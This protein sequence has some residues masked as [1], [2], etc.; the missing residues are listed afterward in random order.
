MFESLEREAALNQVGIGLCL[1]AETL[2]WFFNISFLHKEG[3]GNYTQIFTRRELRVPVI[4]SIVVM[5]TQQFTGC[6]AVFAYSTDMFINAGID[7]W[8]FL[9]LFIFIK[10]YR[11][12]Q[13]FNKYHTKNNNFQENS[14]IQYVGS[15]NGIF[16]LCFECAVFDWA[17]W[18]TNIAN[19][20]YIFYK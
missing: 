9:N 8:V 1:E 15:G 5:I 6:S 18:K 14:K 13:W 10:Y 17:S 19:C 20:E 4:I 16:L 3:S 2:E 11:Q 12:I 7:A